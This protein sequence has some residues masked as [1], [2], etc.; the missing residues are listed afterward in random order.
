L[1]DKRLD[2]LAVTAHPDDAELICGGTLIRCVDAGYRVGALELTGGESGSRGDAGRRAREAEAAAE[3]MGLAVRESLGLPDAHLVDSVENRFK[4]AQAIRRLGPRVLILHNNESWRHPDHGV[5][6]ALGRAAAFLAGL[7]M[8]PGEGE[9]R[10]PE[11]ILY[12]QAYVEHPGKPSFVVDISDQFERKLEAVMCFA[13]QFEGKTE[14]GELFPNG[15]NLPELI[16]TRC[17][18]YG[19]WIRAAYGEPFFVNETLEVQDIVKMGV[20][21]I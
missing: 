10:R 21:S 13:S 17:A 18:H 7:K 11:K 4:L 15:Q 20:K 3:V 14:A 16:R 2:V 12:C 5:A 19:T 6:V 1:S 9:P 8:L